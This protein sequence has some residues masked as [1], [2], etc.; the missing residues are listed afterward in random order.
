ME[1]ITYLK[2]EI[3]TLYTGFYIHF[4][5]G[6]EEIRG[7]ILTILGIKYRPIFIPVSIVVSLLMIG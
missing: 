1:S 6:D 2:K 3:K 5:E 4:I 7:A